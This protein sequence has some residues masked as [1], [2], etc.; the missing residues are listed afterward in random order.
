MYTEDDR[1]A[2]VD[3]FRVVALADT[4]RTIRSMEP[5]YVR[6]KK[7]M[8]SKGITQESLI[9]ALGVTTRGAVGHYLSGRRDLSTD[10]LRDLATCIDVSLDWLLTGIGEMRP[11]HVS[12]ETSHNGPAEDKANIVPSS[13][14]F[15]NLH[16]VATPRSQEI[17]LRL[18]RLAAEGKLTDTDW[19]LLDEIATRFA[20]TADY[21]RDY[22][23]LF[24]E[25]DQD[26]G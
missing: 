19:K 18:E 20:G 11:T 24:Q 6:A 23:T 13:S 5:W 7:V 25:S 3:T 14:V 22:P 12:H 1:Q 16:A 8:K 17:L 9:N 2:K 10:Q 4:L 21:T 26:A 15:R